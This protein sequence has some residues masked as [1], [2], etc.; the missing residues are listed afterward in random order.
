M[1]A[2]KVQHKRFTHG[3]LYLHFVAIRMAKIVAYWTIS[4]TK[5]FFRC[6]GQY[7][8][9]NTHTF[10]KISLFTVFCDIDFFK[11][12][13]QLAL[14]VICEYIAKC[15]D[16][17]S[18]CC[19]VFVKWWIIFFIA[20]FCPIIYLVYF[21]WFSI[22]RNWPEENEE[23]HA[24]LN[25]CDVHGLQLFVDPVSKNWKKKISLNVNTSIF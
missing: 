23:K 15:S 8:V 9:C 24:F 14:R 6:I 10:I 19:R 1:R 22:L 20:V 16:L 12:I 21:R 4:E 25:K 13:F 3:I 7:V 5:G 11:R 18:W 17:Y 2:T